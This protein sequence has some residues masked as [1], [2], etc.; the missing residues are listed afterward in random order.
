MSRAP[1]FPYRAW[2][3]AARHSWKVFDE[4]LDRALR[5]APAHG[6]NVLEIQDYFSVPLLGWVD[7]AAKYARVP[8]LGR[9]E[10]LRFDG[11][12]LPRGGRRAIAERLRDAA[13]K[14]RAAGLELQVWY[15]AMRDWPAEALELCPELRDAD[16]D[17]LYNFLGDSLED[18]FAY[19]PEIT[20]LTLT[21]LHETRS[22]LA[23]PGKTPPAERVHRLYSAIAAA[24]EKHGRRL[25]L[26]DF[27]ARKA[28]L[29]AFAAAAD[30]LPDTVWIQ[31]KNVFG[32]WAPHEKPVNP[33]F[34]R[35]ARGRKPWV[36]E[37]EL[38]NNYT[39]EME[40]PWCDPEQVWRHL[41]LLAELGARGAVG[42]LVNA[43]E[44]Q[45]G[46]IFDT[47]NEV[48]V[49]AFSRALADPGRLLREPGDAFW[50][51]YDAF[52]ESVWSDW[53]RARFGDA[54]APEVARVLKQTPRLAKLTLNLGGAFFFWCQ[55]KRNATPERHHRMLDHLVMAARRAVETCGPAW[56]L[57]EKQEAT[58]LVEAAFQTIEELGPSLPREARE[59][60]EAAY[61]RARGIVTIYRELAAAFVHACAGDL[62]RLREATATLRA[63]ADAAEM[64]WS[65]RFFMG[66]P[67]GARSAADY[68]EKLPSRWAELEANKGLYE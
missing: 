48:N 46:T 37:F 12:P 31:T 52:D 61:L 55:Y 36:V 62:G 40:L 43:E 11:Q 15:H 4:T 39:G 23:L 56:V 6:V 35:Y 2:S 42:R 1:H 66:T 44:V 27:V 65:P 24:C 57:H 67:R 49:A 16:G 32:D 53:A 68:L 8:E 3:V 60:L 38:A 47:P 50:H 29:D 7:A 54:A 20:G 25:I 9:A 58:A 10:S 34:F 21:S 41:R 63:A 45:A 17:A 19:F 30:R 51:D 28:D 5:E 18:A 59:K 22:V 14:V 26:R 33:A 64:A 13:R